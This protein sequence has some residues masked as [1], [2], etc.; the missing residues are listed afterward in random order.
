MPESVA[1]PA[2]P[3][4][5]RSRR[6]ATAQRGSHR[7]DLA[8][9]RRARCRTP[10]PGSVRRPGGA[11]HV[12]RRPGHRDARHVLRRGQCD[13]QFHLQLVGC[14]DECPEDSRDRAG[15]VVCLRPAGRR[16]H[17]PPRVDSTLS[18]LTAGLGLRAPPTKALNPGS[19]AQNTSP[20]GT[21][22]RI[23]RCHSVLKI[24][25]RSAGTR[26]LLAWTSLPNERAIQS[27]T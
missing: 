11:D 2:R 3:H 1:R 12:T 22:A 20:S 26:D 27:R 24:R 10:G 25:G 9:L 18:S 13:R 15:P 7:P 6:R 14:L 4:L 17:P 19:R 5:L 16:P 23:D 21:L 8:L